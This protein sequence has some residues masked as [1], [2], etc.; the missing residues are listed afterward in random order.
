MSVPR[1]PSER[2][3]PSASAEPV[4]KGMDKTQ[5][6]TEKIMA[7]TTV[8]SAL[9]PITCTSRAVG[10]P[11]APWAITIL[12]CATREQTDKTC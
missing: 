8:A 6:N 4:P 2:E 12:L 11:D 5:K 9:L 1:P 10:E 7:S 3:I